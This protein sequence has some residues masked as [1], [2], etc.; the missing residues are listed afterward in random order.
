MAE[1]E[2]L[3]G[4][5]PPAKGEAMSMLGAKHSHAPRVRLH[6]TSAAQA[7]NTGQAVYLESAAIGLELTLWCPR[8]RMRGDATNY[9][10]GIGDVLKAKGHR[11]GTEHLAQLAQVAFYD[12]DRQI[13]E[14]H[15]YWQQ[16]VEA[17]YR[18]RL[19]RI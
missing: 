9:L 18:L 5:Y 4:G 19:W 16:A 12:N 6:L 1:I 11:S 8:D 13:E 15:Y 7:L 17:S 10:G 14:V 2:L 3:V